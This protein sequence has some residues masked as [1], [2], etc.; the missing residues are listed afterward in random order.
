MHS[1]RMHT[2][3]LV[4]VGGGES[5]MATPSQNPLYGT[6]YMAPFME[7]PFMEPPFMDKSPT[8]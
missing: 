1:S 4:T 7:P 5:V 8:P 6:P 2:A 3:H